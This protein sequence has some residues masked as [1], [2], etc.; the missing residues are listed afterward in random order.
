MATAEQLKA[1]MR[2]HA[3]GD[4]D[5]FRSIAMQIAAHAARKGNAQ[6]ASDLKQ[7]VNELRDSSASA[8]TPRAVPIARPV[9][10]LN[11]LIAASFP[12]TR[13]TD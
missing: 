5:R 11:G 1:L 7:L 3:A 12:G 10:E 4:D 13:L 9:G 6:L 2:S 8:L